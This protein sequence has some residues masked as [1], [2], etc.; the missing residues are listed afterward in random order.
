LR[1][2]EKKFHILVTNNRSHLTDLELDR[3]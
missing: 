3:V 1:Y 2:D